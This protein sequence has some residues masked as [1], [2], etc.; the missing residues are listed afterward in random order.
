V[1]SAVLDASALLALLNQEPGS[2]EVASLVAAGA[3]VSAASLSEVIAK[4]S[5]FGMAEPLI[6]D[7]LDSLALEVVP[8]DIDL[9]YRTAMLVGST[10]S[11]GLSIGDRACLA[12]AGQLG[13]PA[14]TADR[15]WTQMDPG[16]EIRVIR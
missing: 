14:V 6:R 4:L 5:L 3:A 10:R 2:D 13:L 9:A 16:V 11:S 12:L 15:A 8:F 1:S 7:V